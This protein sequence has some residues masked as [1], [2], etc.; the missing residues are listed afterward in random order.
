[1]KIVVSKIICTIINQSTDQPINRSTKNQFNDSII[2]RNQ[3]SRIFS[4]SESRVK[5]I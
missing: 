5:F 3:K 1:M 2:T 4:I